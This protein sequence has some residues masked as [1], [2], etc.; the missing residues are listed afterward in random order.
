GT[1]R[2][3]PHQTSP[4]VPPP[5]S[6]WS[7]VKYSALGI[8]S[9]VTLTPVSWVNFGRYSLSV[10]TSLPVRTCSRTSPPSFFDGAGTCC[11]AWVGWA[12]G[13][14]CVAA[15]GCATGAAGWATVAAGFGASVGLAAG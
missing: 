15:A 3:A 12:A 9:T 7:L 6:V 5:I 13:A 11:A 8:A 4:A 14:G 10:S 2:Q 1:S